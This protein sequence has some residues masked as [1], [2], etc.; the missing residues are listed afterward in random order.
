MKL[1]GIFKILTFP[2]MWWKKN[3]IVSWCMYVYIIACA[4]VFCLFK[5]RKL[6]GK[7]CKWLKNHAKGQIQKIQIKGAAKG[8]VEES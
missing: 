5:L 2:F 8:I 6:F 3:H 7:Q 4:I 1:L